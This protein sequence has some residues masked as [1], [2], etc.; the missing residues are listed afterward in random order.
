M[1]VRVLFLVIV[2]E[3]VSLSPSHGQE[4][5]PG[6]TLVRVTD[7]SMGEAFPSINN[8]SQIV[9]TA[10]IGTDNT[11]ME[12]FLYDGRTGETEQI[13]NN[14]T[15]DSV[16]SINDVGAIAWGQVMGPQTPDGRWAEI[17]FRSSDGIVTRITDNEVT[18]ST[19]AINNLNQLAWWR[20]NSRGCQ[21]AGRDVMF[22]DGQTTRQLTDNDWGNQ[23]IDL[24]DAGD[25]IWTEFN[26]CFPGFNWRSKIKL[27]RDGRILTL[28]DDDDLAAQSSTINN[29]GVCAWSFVNRHTFDEGIHLWEN[30]VTT[31]FSNWGRRPV[32]NDLGDIAMQHQENGQ[33]PWQV[34]LY[35]NGEFIQLSDPAWDGITPSI[36]NAGEVAW[37]F[38]EIS[39]PDIAYMRRLD[40][41]DLNC[42]GTINALDIEGFLQAMFDPENF[43]PDCDPTL[44]DINAD[45][46]VNALDIEPFIGLL[47]P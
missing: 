34:W 44:A 7:T 39:A 22:F 29:I 27:Y 11:T 4:L 35:F 33:P 14:N 37:K 3:L 38:G 36:N 47:F 1:K 25:I 6:Y 15:Q 2:V 5:P 42:D 21:E 23:A 8:L 18:D 31:L 40:A 32:L 30:G 9:F 12:I 19:P 46:T 24:N 45:G 28:L 43:P 26:F 10:R 41:G 20:L 16:P 17:M 13:T